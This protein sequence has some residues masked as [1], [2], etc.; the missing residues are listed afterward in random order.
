MARLLEVREEWSEDEEFVERE[1]PLQWRYRKPVVQ[2]CLP[3]LPECS[4]LGAR[5]PPDLAVELDDR[6][7]LKEFEPPVALRHPYSEQ[8][9]LLA[10]ISQVA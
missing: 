8:R 9:H 4:L 6:A 2:E 5:L 3:R 10:R 1:C 7:L